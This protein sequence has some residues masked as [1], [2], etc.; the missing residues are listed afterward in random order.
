M[1]THFPLP[2]FAGLQTTGNSIFGNLS[3][4]MQR[5]SLI[6]CSR[7]QTFTS[8][9]ILPDKFPQTFT[10][11]DTFPHSRTHSIFAHILQFLCDGLYICVYVGMH[12][13]SGRGNDLLKIGEMWYDYESHIRNMSRGGVNVQHLRTYYG[14]QCRWRCHRPLSRVGIDTVYQCTGSGGVVNF[15]V[16]LTKRCRNGRVY[17]NDHV[18]QLICVR[19]IKHWINWL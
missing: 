16:P 1:E 15:L 3:D 19:S 18:H 7:E 9:H 17:D 2:F 11:S 10:H 12:A 4:L 13:K 8:G 6:G 5:S 14:C